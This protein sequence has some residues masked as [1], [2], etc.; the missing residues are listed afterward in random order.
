MADIVL[1]VRKHDD[2]N[3]NRL[4]FS[5]DPN[6]F[7][8]LRGRL[9]V[10]IL[11]DHYVNLH[12]QQ[13][14]QQN[15]VYDY[16]R[17]G[18]VHMDC[19][20]EPILQDAWTEAKHLC[21]AHYQTSPSVQFPIQSSIPNITCIR[22]WLHYCLVEIFKNSMVASLEMVA[23]SKMESN[24]SLPPTIS[25][26][27]E[28]TTR[29]SHT[30]NEDSWI[31]VKIEDSGPGL[32]SKNPYTFASCSEKWDRLHIQQSYA[33]VRSPL[34]SM[35]VGVPSSQWLMQHFGGDL[36]LLN[37]TDSHGC[38]AIL[39]IPRNDEILEYLPDE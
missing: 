8:F 12:K 35:G 33:S 11:C 25:I 2:V 32:V 9:S 19:P 38:T 10:Q 5:Q 7:Y 13:Q 30:N 1:L 21:E 16:T 36:E 3:N 20:L 37:R 26:S 4:S 17:H 27:V 39:W 24:E 18:A 28:E 14:Q 23:S 34:S 31:C 6:L 15:H 22:P 29:S